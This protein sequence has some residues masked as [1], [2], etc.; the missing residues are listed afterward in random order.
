MQPVYRTAAADQ[1]LLPAPDL[2]SKPASCLA[3]VDRLDRQMGGRWTER[4]S[5][6]HR[7][8]PLKANHEVNG[9]QRLK[10]LQHSAAV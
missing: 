4:H 9:E 6:S 3:D 8:A 7:I 1:Y 2:S 10:A 5:V